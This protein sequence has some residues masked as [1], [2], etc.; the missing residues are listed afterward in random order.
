MNPFTYAL[1]E[2]RRR[3]YRTLINILGFAIAVT[4]LITL[5]M[6][7]RGWEACTTKPLNNIGTDIIYIYTA[8]IDPSNKGC[9]IVNHL[10][11]YPFN[12]TLLDEIEQLPNV[13]SAVPILM[14]RLRAMVFTGIDPSETV[15]N[16]V[17]PR[18]VI[19]GR[20]LNPDDGYVALIDK[21]YADLNNLTLGSIVN[22][23]A[24][25]EVVG[26]VEVS[27]TNIMK[28]HIYVNLPVV[29]Q[30]LPEQPIGLVNI[31]LIRTV[32]PTTVEETAAALEKQ[33]PNSSIL[34]GSDLADT[35]FSIIR[36]NEETAWSFSLALVVI[37]VLFMVKSQLGNVS[38]RT[39]EIGILK[40]I[41]W[42][43]SNVVN[44]IVSE[45]L[46]Q[47]TIGGIVGCG[48]GYIFAMYVLSTIGG[49]IGGALNLVTVD[50]LL[51]G[52]GF[53]VAI[54]TG[55]TAGLFSSLRAARLTPVKAIK[56]I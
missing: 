52:I 46:I 17:L 50:P 27:A 55:V 23:V 44:Q 33:W 16:A 24:D 28:S 14:H 48:L 45:S 42:S 21:E 29:Q 36:I 51:F 15:T 4:T 25:Y 34:T 20:Y 11:S 3:K 6:A 12:Q 1:K 43:N 2:I 13:E 39:K 30:V 7:A 38:E 49:E 26:I 8:P 32:S 9:Y 47:A 31:G 56:T 10:F 35:A 40:A 54:L 41:G 5:V 19:E 37:T 22:Y 53:S 18:D